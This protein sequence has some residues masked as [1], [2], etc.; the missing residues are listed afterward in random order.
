METRMRKKRIGAAYRYSFSRLVLH[1]YLYYDAGS[2][3]DGYDSLTVN[4]Q[5]LTGEEKALETEFCRILGEFLE[6]K[7]RLEELEELRRKIIARTE[8]LTAYSDCF[9]IYEYVLNRVERRFVTREAP[10]YTPAEIAEQVVH[11]LAGLE[12]RAD[13][14]QWIRDMVAQLPVRYTRQKFYGM[15]MERFTVYTGVERGSMEN[16]LYMLKTSAMTGLP[17]HMEQE[18]ALYEILQLFRGTDFKK[19]DKEG[20]G[21][22]EDSMREAGRLLTRKTDFYVSLQEMVNELYV[23]FLTEGEAVTDAVEKQA[24]LDGA[25]R[26]LEALSEGGR[27]LSEQEDGGILYRMEGIQES[28]MD[29]VAAGSPEQDEILT[30]VDRLVSGSAFM[31]VEEKET[32]HEEADRKWLEEQAAEFCRQ[33]GQLFAQVPKAVERAV[34]AKVLSG[35]PVM[36]TSSGEVYEHVRASLESCT[37]FAEREACMEL[38]EQEL[39]K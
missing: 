28:V 7:G 35:L 13:Q 10:D 6:G 15:V 18:D 11:Y 27:P 25:K 31:P 4:R 29:L 33:L 3:E 23:L 12:Q 37:D 22:C 5:E 32:C 34:M 30:K 36:F 1:L 8:I 38:L 24:F 2:G 39:M 26:L 20:F 21:R 19:L 14:N 16:F 9:Q 17:E